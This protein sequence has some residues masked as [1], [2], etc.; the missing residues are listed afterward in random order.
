VINAITLFIGE[1]FIRLLLL[2]TSQFKTVCKDDSGYITQLKQ[3]KSKKVI[4]LS[5]TS[6][7]IVNVLTS[8]ITFFDYAHMEVWFFW[9]IYFCNADVGHVECAKFSKYE[10]Q[11]MSRDA[12]GWVA[13][14]DDHA[15]R[16]RLRRRRR[17][18]DRRRFG[19]P[20]W[21]GNGRARARR[22]ESDTR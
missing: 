15:I 10:M 8:N 22:T 1:S 12:T 20:P 4:L 21:S 6:P 14:L 19:P 9:P 5:S 13:A 3:Q 7:H 2:K 11:E 16:A 18:V 17:Q